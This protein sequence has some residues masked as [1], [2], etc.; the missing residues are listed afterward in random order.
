MLQ[1]GVREEMGTASLGVSCFRILY[2]F[3]FLHCILYKCI[4]VDDFKISV[5]TC[6]Q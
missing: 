6:Q 5:D 3:L 2:V 4:Y 1:S